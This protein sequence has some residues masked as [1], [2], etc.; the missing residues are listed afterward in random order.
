[1]AARETGKQRA[2]RIPLDYYKHPDRLARWKLALTALATVAALG[3]WASGLALGGRDGLSSSNRGR[4]RYS[5]GPVARVHAAWDAKCDACHVP[6]TPISGGASWTR[7][8]GADTHA[9]DARCQTCHAGPPHHAD[10]EK[11]EEVASCAG[12]HRDHRGRDASLVRL[13]DK[14]CTTCH[15]ELTAHTRAGKASYANIQAFDRDHSEFR[16]KSAYDPGHLKFNHALHMSEGLTTV[17]DRQGQGGK[18]IWTL[19]QIPADRR[20]QY[21]RSGQKDGEAVRLDCASCHRTVADEFGPSALASAG[22]PARVLPGR[23]PGAYMLP[24]VY[25]NQCAACHVLQVPDGAGGA[26][27]VRHRL[28]PKALHAELE[29]AFVGRYLASDPGAL[30]HFRPVRKVPGPTTPQEQQARE[31]IGA[32][33]AAAEKVLFG[34]AKNTCTECH[35]YRTSDGKLVAQPTGGD[36]SALKIE[37]AN[38][39]ATWFQH[40]AFDHAAHRAVSC[41]E[42]HAGA[43]PEGQGPQVSDLASA[44]P[45]TDHRDV[46]LPGIKTCRQCHAPSHRSEGLAL[47]GAGHECTECHTYHDGPRPDAPARGLGD[48]ARDARAELGLRPFLDGA[49]DEPPPRRP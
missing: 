8:L 20:E 15:A 21:R 5:H 13:P 40:A 39:P 18:A 47:G 14:D 46:L 30:D 22:L 35:D 11:P 27:P 1:M 49:A 25:E 6:F 33:V 38:I 48:P 29:N 10:V 24:I 28:Q 4:L 32:Q 41:K 2:A 9:A 12:C 19:A 23:G 44:P 3:W 36:P 7:T 34:G 43:Y 17:K 45:S 26:V 37:P 42:C 16:A 31:A